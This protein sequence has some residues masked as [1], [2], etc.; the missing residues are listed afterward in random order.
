MP[1]PKAVT[2]QD[3]ALSGKDRIRITG[4]KKK[5]NPKQNLKGK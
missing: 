2:F 1:K 4:W 3:L 5:N